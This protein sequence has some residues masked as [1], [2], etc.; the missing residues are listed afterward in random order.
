MSVGFGAFMKKALEDDNYVFYEYGSYN[1]NDVKY[2]NENRKMDG[3]IMVKKTCF[4]EP[5]IHR[6]RKRMPN[7]KEKLIEKRIPVFV[8]YGSMLN[9][10]D[11]K[12]ENCCNTWK[13]NP[14]GIDV[15]AL[16]LLF[17]L[18]LQ[19]QEESSVPEAISY[20]V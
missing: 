12:I 13:V 11:I 10:G 2:R 9:K 8:D 4:V 17:K 18:F 15:M 7:K 20:N 6:K 1:L 5:E 3:L 16:R 19:Y 14:S